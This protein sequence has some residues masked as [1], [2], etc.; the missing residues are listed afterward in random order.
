MIPWG[1]IVALLIV[2]VASWVVGFMMGLE[3][4]ENS[5]PVKTRPPLPI[6]D[7]EEYVDFCESVW[8]TPGDG[9][10]R[11]GV[12]DNATQVMV[13]GLP[14]EVGEICEY[15]KKMIRD[16][17]VDNELLLKEFGDVLY[18]LLMLARS[19]GFSVRDIVDANTH[20]LAGR[21]ERGTQR[22]SGDLR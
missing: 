15:I 19:F 11:H 13:L 16:G 14:G 20:K 12:L 21:V 5:V 2:A 6:R 1:W 4:D 9:L 17:T 8:I 3:F 10:V 22:G 7:M 18:Y